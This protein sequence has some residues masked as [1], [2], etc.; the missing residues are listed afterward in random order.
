MKF[1]DRVLDKSNSYNY[2]KNN[3]EKIEKKYKK[4]IKEIKKLKNENTI[5]NKNLS[6]S[7]DEIIKLQKRLGKFS[8]PIIMKKLIDEEYSDLTI[9]I[10][11]PN[12]VGH[13]HWGD[14]FFAVALK[15]SFEKKGFNVL[16]HERENWYDTTVKA[17]INIILRGKYEFTPMFDAINVMWN[18]YDPEKIRKEEYEQFDIC[19]I[20][21][22]R[23]ANEL[24]EEL[25]TT[26]KPLLQCTDPDIFYSEYDDSISEDILFVGSTRG[27][28]REII[29]DI[30]ETDFDVA[31]YGRGWPE[32]ID[33]QYVNGFF[34]PNEELHK[35]YSSCKILLNDH[36]ETMRELDFPSNRLFDA[37][38]CGTFVISDKIPSAET[39][40]EGNVVTYDGVDDLN[41]KLEYY[42]THD[43]ER[44]KIAEKGKKI[45]LKNHTF[46]NRADEIL[47]ELKNLN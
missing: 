10:K 26:V 16:I 39:L 34:I 12:P 42:L 22:I 18:I 25:N 7:Y 6:S 36:W 37:L 19:F 29:K 13:H 9:A 8:K 46:D 11:T 4:S 38:A 40:F 47:S 15:K 43:E 1:V 3:Y 24:S 21:S 31:V 41:S 44:I 23:Y 28:Y 17:D 14:Y 33:E 32:F 20:S 30:M 35:Y 45:V 27:F 2:Y 5:L